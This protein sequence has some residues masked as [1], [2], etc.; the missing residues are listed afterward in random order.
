M[1]EVTGVLADLPARVPGAPDAR[2]EV[3][4]AVD[5]R[6]PGEPKARARPGAKPDAQN[7]SQ[8]PKR[9]DT[10]GHTLDKTLD[11]FGRTL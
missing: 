3:L 7:Q 8:P 4:A 11:V 5:K 10:P 6:M 2:A 1:R 9:S